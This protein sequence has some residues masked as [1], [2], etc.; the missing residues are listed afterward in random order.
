MKENSGFGEHSKSV[1]R[2]IASTACVAAL[3]H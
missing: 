2:E 3:E 1:A